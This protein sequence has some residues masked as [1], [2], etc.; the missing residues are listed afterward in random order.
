MNEQHSISGRINILRQAL[1]SDKSKVAFLLGAGCPLSIQIEGNRPLIPDI[2]GLTKTVCAKLDQAMIQ[3]LK[4]GSDL[5][6]GNGVTIEDI[7][8]RVR[9]LIDVIGESKFEG[10]K[11]QDLTDMERSICDA[12]TKEVDKELP[13]DITPYHNLASWISGIPREH[14]VEVFTPNYDLLMEASLESKSIPYFDGFVGSRSAFFDLHSVEHEK[15]PSR[16]VRLWKL[17]GSVNWWLDA[18]GKVFR[19][20]PKNK[21]SN[22][23]MIYPSHLKYLQSRRMPYLAMQDRLS[24]FLS[25]GQSVLVTS[26]YSFGDQHLNEIITQRLSAN[27]RTVCFGLLYHDIEQYTEALACAK[28]T[29]NLH[30]LAKNATSSAGKDGRWEENE[31]GQYNYLVDKQD[32]GKR[33]ICKIGDF[34]SFSQFLLRQTGNYDMEGQDKN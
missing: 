24:S 6:K 13:D 20:T 21:A 29:T 31:D 8:S 17:H 18:N 34:A 15:I 12:I 2:A 5:S 28:Q 26:G 19:G 14:P 9:S 33:T 11:K 4:K 1:A 7:L 32:D 27:P 23:Q 25:T 3:K 10:L 30:L 16:W 22:K